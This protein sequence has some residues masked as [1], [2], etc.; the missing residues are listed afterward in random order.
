MSREAHLC[1]HANE[2]PTSLCRCPADCY[3]RSHTCKDASEGPRVPR[4]VSAVMVGVGAAI[5]GWAIPSIDV[6][7][8]LRTLHGKPRVATIAEH[9][10]EVAAARAARRDG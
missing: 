5:A 4:L 2:V 3:C 10:A 7:N 9:D 1:E 6:V 8:A